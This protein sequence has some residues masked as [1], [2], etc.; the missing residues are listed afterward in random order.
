MDKVMPL[1]A[2]ILNLQR[3]ENRTRKGCSAS[4]EKE[5]KQRGALAHQDGLK[6]D[7]EAWMEEGVVHAL[8]FLGLSPNT[9]G[10][11]TVPHLLI[12]VE[13]VQ[14]LQRGPDELQGGIPVG[15]GQVLAS[16]QVTAGL[17]LLFLGHLHLLLL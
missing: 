4:E 1:E 12:L 2:H 14:V 9:H 8:S 10:L 15:E 11:S 5:P 16:L 13:R 6:W 17:E 3:P 7:P